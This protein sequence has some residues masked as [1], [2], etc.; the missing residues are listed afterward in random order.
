MTLEIYKLLTTNYA[1]TRAINIT[2]SKGSRG[3]AV[4]NTEFHWMMTNNKFHE[5]FNSLSP[6]KFE[7]KYKW[8]SRQFQWLVAEVPYMRCPQMNI[9][10]SYWWWVNLGLDN[11]LVT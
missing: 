6:G 4:Y 7:F 5:G 9:T 1:I 11:G 8:Y 2:V 10:G 3:A